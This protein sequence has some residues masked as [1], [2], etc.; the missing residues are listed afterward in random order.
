[1]IE[2]MNEWLQKQKDEKKQVKIIW[3]DNAGENNKLQKRFIILIGSWTCLLSTQPM[4]H[5]SKILWQK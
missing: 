4:K 5:H 3:E 1:M 2:P